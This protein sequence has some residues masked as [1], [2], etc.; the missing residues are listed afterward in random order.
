MLKFLLVYIMNLGTF[1]RAFC[2]IIKNYTKAFRDIVYATIDCS[3]NYI[4]H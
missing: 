2:I 4:C 1:V 3:N